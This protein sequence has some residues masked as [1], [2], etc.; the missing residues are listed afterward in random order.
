MKEYLNHSFNANDPDLISVIDELPV[1]SAPFGFKLLEKVKMKPGIRFLDI[2]CGLG[3]PLTELAQRLGK[4]ASA[5]GLDPWDAAIDRV[6]LKIKTYNLQNVNMIS[7][8]AEDIPFP[9]GHF[10]LVVSNNGINNVADMK[11]SLSECGRVSKP[12]AQF[13]IT[14][15]LAG[16]MIEFYTAFEKVLNT[17]GL[18][19]EVGKMKEHIYH[20][21]RPVE[22]VKVLIEDAG[23][24]VAEI[25]SDEF[26]LKFLD[27]ESMF[28]HSFIKYW[29]LGAWKELLKPEDVEKIFTQIEEEINSN[30]KEG[31]GL[32]LTIPFVTIDSRK[33]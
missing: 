13:I 27:A 29:F 28:N 23:F 5:Y 4:T 10:D 24:E 20:K 11:K 33:L 6:M 1:W 2:G 22:E 17:N 19:D 12:G 31:E 26:K 8:C 7:G 25:E 3:F 16:S 9:D 32:S 18:I 21:R 15:N 30:I 14:F